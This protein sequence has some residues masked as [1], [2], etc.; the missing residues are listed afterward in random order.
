MDRVVNYS[1]T[2][3]Q[4][5]E[6]LRKIAS[7]IPKQ[8]FKQITREL[9]GECMF[10]M[11]Q[12]SPSSLKAGRGYRGPPL[13]FSIEVKDRSSGTS[14]PAYLVTPT[15][16]VHSSRGSHNLASI[17]E[18][19]SE[20]GQLLVPVNAQ[21]M[22]FTAITTTTTGK[23]ATTK[24]GKVRKS[25]KTPWG[26]VILTKKTEWSTTFSRGHRRGDIPPQR[27]IQRTWMKMRSIATEFVVD[28]L[29]QVYERE[30]PR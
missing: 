1:I 5:P 23:L 28:K 14:A 2:L 21:A 16:M 29:V 26:T 17:L 12:Y 18:A 15:K 24:T 9:A 27:F 13:R 19:G 10:Y 30:A 11:M 7:D 25:K 3:N 4:L 22:K 8:Y 20:G 6:T